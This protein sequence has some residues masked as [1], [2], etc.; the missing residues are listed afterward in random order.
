M[1]ILN[2]AVCISHCVYTPGKDEHS[3]ILLSAMAKIVGK[4]D[5]FNLRIATNLEDG[6]V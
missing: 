1:Q 3:I 4:T 5:L 6:K 2:K